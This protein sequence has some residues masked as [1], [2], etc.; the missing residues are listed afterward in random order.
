MKEQTLQAKENVVAEIKEHIEQAKSVTIV[1]YNGVNVE[2]ITA[3]RNKY[4]EADVVYKVYK[5]TMVRRAFNELGTTDLDEVLNGPNAFVFSNNE[6][7]DGPKISAEFAKDN[8][9]KFKILAG[10]M[11]GKAMSADEVVALSKLPG[12]EVLLSMVLRGLQGPI[13]GFANVSQ[14]ILRKT[15]YAFNAIKEKKEEEG[16]A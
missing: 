16:A 9:E 15:V 8:E 1:A 2:Q 10:Y 7:V 13:A 6:M 5:N 12:K 14:G 3:L 11:D 4:R